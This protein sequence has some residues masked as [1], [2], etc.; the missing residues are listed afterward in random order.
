MPPWD[1]RHSGFKPLEDEHHRFLAALPQHL[2][3]TSRN[4]ADHIADKTART[5]VL[6]HAVHSLCT[7][8]LYRE[9]M[10]FLPWN[11]TTPIGP[12]DEP[13]IKTE[14]PA[15]DPDYWVNQAR[16]CFGAARSFADL[17][18][19]CQSANALVDTPIAGFASY[20]VAW[21]GTLTRFLFRLGLNICSMLLQFF[22]T[23]GPRPCLANP[24]PAQRMGNGC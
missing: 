7:I 10:A 23:Y 21:C 16:R 24:T 12:L 20:I 18:R 5:Y 2:V 22:P 17:L 19:A 4:T 11:V 6:I 14:V 1:E 8:S 15:D 13:R 3:L 9:Y